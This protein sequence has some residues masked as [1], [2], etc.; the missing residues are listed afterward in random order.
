MYIQIHKET[1]ILCNNYFL[2]INR[3]TIKRVLRGFSKKVG[4]G[5]LIF[6]EN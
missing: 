5:A 2:K 3:N 1:D 4:G 6:A